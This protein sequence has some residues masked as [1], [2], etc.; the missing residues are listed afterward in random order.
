MKLIHVV[1]L[2]RDYNCDSDHFLVQTKIK[3]KLIPAKNR[4][5]QKY[6]WDGQLLN[7]KENINKC[8]ENLQSKLQEIDEET[9]I[10]QDGQNL[11]QVILETATEFRLS[12]NV[13]NGNHW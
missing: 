4:Q 7:E 3:Q 13:K 2:K 1:R 9:D 6:K 10:N 12:K 5:T 11:K 8:H